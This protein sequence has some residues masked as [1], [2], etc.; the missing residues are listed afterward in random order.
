MGYLYFKN[1]HKYFWYATGVEYY[2]SIWLI[3]S[4]VLMD[5]G[6]KEMEKKKKINMK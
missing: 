5:T 1:F 4:M 6:M 3:I 2:L